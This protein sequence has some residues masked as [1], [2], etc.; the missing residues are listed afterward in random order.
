[1]P[2]PAL[3]EVDQRAVTT[4]DKIKQGEIE[5]I[6]LS[7]PIPV[8]QPKWNV[9]PQVLHLD[10]T[11]RKPF[12]EERRLRMETLSH[13]MARNMPGAPDSPAVVDALIGLAEFYYAR[14]MAPEGLSVLGRLDDARLAPGDL[15][16]RAALELALGLMDPRD[17]PLTPR[18]EKLLGKEY[19][20]WPDQPLFLAMRAIREGNE[21]AAGPLMRDIHVRLPLFPQDVRAEFLPHLL[22]V[23]VETRQW[24]IARDFAGA[25]HDHDYLKDS[26][27]FYFLLGRAAE[28]GQDLLAA[29][30]SYAM[31]VS[32]HS[33][34]G[35]RARRA[36]VTMGLKNN[37]LSVGEARQM[38]E[39]EAQTWRGDKHA[40]STM[41]D[42]AALQQADGDTVAAIGTFAAITDRFPHLPEAELIRQKARSLIA[43]IY[44]KGAA[45]KIPLTDFLNAHRRIA[46][47]YRFEAGFAEKAEMFANRFL[48][49]G[50]TLVAAQEFQAIRDHLAVSRD[51]GLVEVADSKL[52]MLTL[53]QADSLMIGGQYDAAAAILADPLTSGDK[54]LLDAR[55]HLL[56]KLYAET[57]QN[58]ALL[59]TSVQHQTIGYLRIKAGAFFERED[60]AG[61]EAAYAELWD[62]VGTDLDFA[63]A[64]QFLLA[65]YR[66]GNTEL[67]MTLA[68]T[69]PKLTDLPQW[70]EI[71]GGLID[72]PAEIWPLRED[73]AQERVE[74]AK[75]TLENV[76]TV[77]NGTN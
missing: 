28:A 2:I 63:D 32:D 48:E 4:I 46:P 67:A 9:P 72:Q 60:W 75:K 41:N 7:T 54:G 50:S 34:W 3:A 13:A 65:S 70:T 74:R 52:D 43:D 29:F 15:L 1:M 18:A 73:S 56:T 58:A 42:L 71:A 76:E 31:A 30:D 35:H 25:F 64:I 19:M 77:T 22:Y 47:D 59:Q 17:R 21:A 62:K 44:E 45:G 37:L 11:D 33:I 61:A 10:E 49:V 68:R 57:G 16:R 20:H 69:F 40:L 53:K 27:Q 12:V 55:A 51:L 24:R 38:L 6:P 66:N 39:Q 23:A 36:M 14:A 26:P 8:A 5:N